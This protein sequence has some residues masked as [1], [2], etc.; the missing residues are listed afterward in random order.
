MQ[1][2]ENIGLDQQIKFRTLLLL[3]AGWERPGYNESRSN[4][5]VV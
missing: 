4:G 3:L 1:E 2:W 5:V